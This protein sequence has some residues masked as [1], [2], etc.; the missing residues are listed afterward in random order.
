[1]RSPSTVWKLKDRLN[2]C[3]KSLMLLTRMPR[4]QVCAAIDGIMDEGAEII[5]KYSNSSVLDADLAA[6]A[7]II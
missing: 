1:M 6:A 4:A 2:G 3:N 7:Q 5:E